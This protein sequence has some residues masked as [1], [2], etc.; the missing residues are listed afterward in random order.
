MA[1][2]SYAGGVIPVILLETFGLVLATTA[3][4]G[5]DGWNETDDVG[6]LVHAALSP[7]GTWGNFLI[8]ILALSTITHNIPNA[9][10]LGL[11]LQNL[12]PRIQ[13]W[14]F[15]LAG[16]CTYT[17]FAVAGS[18]HLYM[19]FQNLL[20]FMT[21]FYGPYVIILIVEHFYFRLGSFKQYPRDAWNQAD[22]LPKGVA[23]WSASLLGYLSAFLGVKQPWYVGPLAQA[24]GLEGGD[25]G[26]PI[27]ISVA[28][29]TYIP[30]RKIERKKEKN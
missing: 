8:G 9:Y 4:S 21:Y 15:T 3:I 11:M 10:G 29:V 5:P 12:F 6:G 2:L 28:A 27:A 14:I 19:L 17:I 25:I 18:D 24:I 13:H 7:L 20:P 1:L 22:L 30:L 23:A 16:V 26:V